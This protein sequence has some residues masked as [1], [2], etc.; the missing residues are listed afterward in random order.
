[1]YLIII[2]LNSV[3]ALGESFLPVENDFLGM[4]QDERSR[5]E[6]QIYP[7]GW[8]FTTVSPEDEPPYNKYVQPDKPKVTFGFHIEQMRTVSEIEKTFSF[9]AISTVCYIISKGYA[10]IKQS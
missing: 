9:D 2:I 6:V 10:A 5:R 4:K 8:K 3:L 7:P 1:M